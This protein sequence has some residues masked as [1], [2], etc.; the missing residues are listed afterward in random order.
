MLYKLT[1]FNG[2]NL[3]ELAIKNGLTVRRIRS[4][5]ADGSTKHP[6]HEEKVAVAKQLKMF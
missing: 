6:Q 5:V 4:I 2:R 3:R 1:E